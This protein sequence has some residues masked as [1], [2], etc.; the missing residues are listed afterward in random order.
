MLAQATTPPDA[1]WH[2]GRRVA[3]DGTPFRLTNTPQVKANTPQVKANTR[4]AK[5]RRGRATFA[6]IPTGVRLELGLHN[7]LAAASGRGGQSEWA[8]ALELLAALPAWAPL[9]ADRL[10]GCAAFVAAAH[11]ACEKV[12]SHFL[13]RACMNIKVQGLQRYKDGRRRVR[14]PVR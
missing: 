11:A 12:G 2:G 6:K 4:K 10:H 9:L 13:I 7:P 8:L 14:V 5:C 3:L 1:F